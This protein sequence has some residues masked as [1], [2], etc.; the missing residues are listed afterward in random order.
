[1][2]D[3]HDQSRQGGPAD[4][5]G[6]IAQA[7]TLAAVVPS[8]RGAAPGLLACTALL[9]L[10]TPRIAWAQTVTVTSP[11]LG[12][13]A[14]AP[15]GV[16]TFR[17]TPAGVVSVLS[18]S[19]TRVST[20]SVEFQV[21]A[22]C[23]SGNCTSKN[24]TVTIASTSGATGRAGTLT[25]FNVALGAG[26]SLVGALPAPGSP[27][28]FTIGPIGKNA[29]AIFTIGADF[30][31]KGDDDKTDATGLAKSPISVTVGSSGAQ[32]ASA[33]ATVF[34]SLSI[35]GTNL[36]FGRI[37]R[38]ATGSSAIVLPAS[39][40]SRQVTGNGIGLPT[41]APKRALFTV[42]GEPSQT[43][44]L[45]IPTSI[46][47]KDAKGDTLTIAASN[48]APSTPMLDANG[49][50]TFYMGGGFS[51]TNTTPTGA[52]TGTFTVTAVYN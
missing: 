40:G 23:S 14:A 9:A 32:P 44:T 50:L 3:F 22:A 21:T 10:S 36:D 1:M 4:G 39:T 31:I 15:S 8:W 26:A 52:Y 51:I 7:Q 49:T 5:Q 37:V 16:T 29:S 47:L 2:R 48:T 42:L 45:T 34:R 17:F 43:L 46:T 30:P 11:T 41:P 6:R 28:T 19:G 38:P 35:S 18:G 12:K 24:S 27:Y 25:N 33:T 13:V 20:G